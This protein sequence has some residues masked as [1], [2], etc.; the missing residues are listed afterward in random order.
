MS[1]LSDAGWRAV[2]SALQIAQQGPESPDVR[3]VDALANF[4][5][6]VTPVP[7]PRTLAE[8]MSLQTGDGDAPDVE[9]L[10]VEWLARAIVKTEYAV[11]QAT[12]VDEEAEII[13]ATYRAI[14]SQDKA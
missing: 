2:R 8:R 9:W 1:N 10:D 4:G 3:F 12:S 5:F 6:A 11:E 13:A 14:A 7:P